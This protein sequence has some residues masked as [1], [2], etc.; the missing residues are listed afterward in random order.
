MYFC[1]SEV[2]PTLREIF[3]EASVCLTPACSPLPWTELVLGSGFHLYHLEEALLPLFSLDKDVFTS[4]ARGVAGSQR[5]DGY[6]QL[7]P[8]PRRC[9]RAFWALRGRRGQCLGLCRSQTLSVWTSPSLRDKAEASW[10]KVHFQPEN[11]RGQIVSSYV[12]I[13][14]RWMCFSKVKE[15]VPSSTLFPGTRASPPWLPPASPQ[16]VL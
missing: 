4:C 8:F 12:L 6:S 3:Q 16:R 13:Y 7:P 11:V 9:P 14:R 5:P 2:R 10:Q 1:A 15:R